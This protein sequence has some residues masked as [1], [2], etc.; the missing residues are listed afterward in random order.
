MNSIDLVKIFACIFLSVLLSVITSYVEIWF[1][2]DPMQIIILEEI[3]L[4]VPTLLLANTM[5]G[6]IAFST[7]SGLVFGLFENVM[8]TVSA[9]QFIVLH[10]VTALISGLSLYPYKRSKNVMFIIFIFIGLCISIGIHYFVNY[11]SSNFWLGLKS[12]FYMFQ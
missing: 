3:I 8:R 5:A 6:I 10:L 1:L 7:I 4:I 12:L 2:K 11:Y 9:P